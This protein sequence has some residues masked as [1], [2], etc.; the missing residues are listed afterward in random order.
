MNWS[1]YKLSVAGV[2]AKTSFFSAF[3]IFSV[4]IALPS[5]EREFMLYE[6]TIGW[7]VAA[8]LLSLAMFL[9]PCSNWPE[10]GILNIFSNRS[11]GGLIFV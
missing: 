6:V 9:L 4:N 5:I 3:L 7:V 10:I 1:R 2:V 8:F 11:F